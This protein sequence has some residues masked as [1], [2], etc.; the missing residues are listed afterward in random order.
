MTFPEF[1]EDLRKHLRGQEI[2]E[3]TVTSQT[4]TKAELELTDQETGEK[5]YIGNAA[6]P[7]ATIHWLG[8]VQDLGNLVKV[9]GVVFSAFPL[10]VA[11]WM[12]Y[13]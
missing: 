13:A 6:S 5:A 9:N 4:D 7:G 8:E 1:L 3:A 2:V 12:T 10:Q 11:T